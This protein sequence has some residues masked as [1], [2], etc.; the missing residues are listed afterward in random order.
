MTGVSMTLRLSAGTFT[1]CKKRVNMWVK[2]IVMW[3][4]LV[5]GIETVGSWLINERVNKSHS[6]VRGWKASERLFLEKEALK[7][8]LG[9]FRIDKGTT[10]LS[11][12]WCN[13]HSLAGQT[14]TPCD[15]VASPG[16]KPKGRV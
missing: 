5:F 1:I 14:L 6:C 13:Q 10:G 11:K 9:K 16:L 4:L 7:D 3:G 2:I 8:R 12:W 15:P